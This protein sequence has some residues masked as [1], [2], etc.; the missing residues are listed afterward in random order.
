MVPKGAVEGVDYDL[1]VLTEVWLATNEQDSKLVAQN[2]QGISS[3]AYEP[4]RYA[5]QQEHGVIQFIDWYCATMG[6]R[7][8]GAG[9]LKV[10]A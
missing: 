4:G 7:L 6:K 8:E 10:V 5:P 2:Q 1:K 9:K 3:P